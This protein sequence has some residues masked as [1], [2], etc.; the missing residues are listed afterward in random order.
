V[1]EVQ[2][3]VPYRRT[4]FQSPKVIGA[5]QVW[6]PTLATAGQ[7]IKVAV[8]DDGVDQTHPFFSPAGFTMPAGFPKGQR[9]Y[10]TAKVIV[11]RAFPPPGANWPYAKAPFD[12]KESEHGTHVAG[13]V[14]GDH[15]TTALGA[16]VSGIAPRAYIGNY[17]IGTISTPGS[18][19]DG[20]SPEI[21][22]RDRAGGQGRDGRDQLLVRRARDHALARHRR[23]GAERR[24]GG[25]SRLRRG[26]G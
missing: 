25:R 20:N 14:A 9:A 5:P 17:R 19:L 21:A 11:A 8:I 13:I 3:S 10:T 4:L 2:A 1:R 6:G 15:D 16:K 12:P 22:A 23:P 24:R 7:G 18:G 26:G